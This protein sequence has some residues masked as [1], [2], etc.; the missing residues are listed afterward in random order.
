MQ[1]SPITFWP[2]ELVAPGVDI[3]TLLLAKPW[4]GQLRGKQETQSSPWMKQGF[5]PIEKKQSKVRFSCGHQCHLTSWFLPTAD[6]GQ[7]L[8]CHS[9]R[10]LN[11]SPQ[12]PDT[13]VGLPRCR[14]CPHISRTEGHTQSEAGTGVPTGYD[15]SNPGGEG[16]LSDGKEMSRPQTHS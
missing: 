2:V 13:V 6:R 16:S 4:C 3:E 5:S 12:G 10:T 7:G 14:W 9:R 1:I 11:T 15:H 8:L